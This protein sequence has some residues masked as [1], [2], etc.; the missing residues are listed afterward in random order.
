MNHFKKNLLALLFLGAGGTVLV[1]A[2]IRPAHA[3]ESE[4]CLKAEYVH[5]GKCQ[6][7]IVTMCSGPPECFQAT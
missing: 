2:V 5:D 6:G 4:S 3:A 1:P 7:A